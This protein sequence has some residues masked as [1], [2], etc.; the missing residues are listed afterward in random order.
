MTRHRVP[1]YAH[2][3]HMRAAVRALLDGAPAPDVDV[4]L[5]ELEAH[6]P[7]QATLRAPDDTRRARLFEAIERG[8]HA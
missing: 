8:K 4:S 1:G 7:E 2:A 5:E 6:E 3:L